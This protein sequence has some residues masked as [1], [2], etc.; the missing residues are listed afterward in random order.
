[1]NISQQYTYIVQ[2]KKA[3]ECLLAPYAT[4]RKNKMPFIYFS[5]FSSIDRCIFVYLVWLY[6][7]RHFKVLALVWKRKIHISVIMENFNM[8]MYASYLCWMLCLFNL[9]YGKAWIFHTFPQNDSFHHM[10]HSHFNYPCTLNIWLI[11]PYL[12]QRIQ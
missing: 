8:S 6:M 10:T 5:L 4:D 2:C 7:C 9:Q 3:R 1:M 11:F 12:F